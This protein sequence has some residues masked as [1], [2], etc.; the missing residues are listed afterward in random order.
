MTLL[1]NWSRAIDDIEE[2][3]SPTPDWEFELLKLG[4]GPLGYKVTQ[5]QLP[6]L[7]VLLETSAQTIRSLQ[8]KRHAAF[9]AATLVSVREP[10][11]WRGSEVTEGQV[12]VFGSLEH[13]LVL[14]EGGVWL[15]LQF[16]MEIAAATGLFCLPAGIWNSDL[17]AHR[18][19]IDQCLRLSHASDLSIL[20]ASNADHQRQD[21]AFML[22]SALMECLEAPAA[23][24][25]HPRYRLVKEADELLHA[26]A[27][28]HRA[29]VE[30]MA[31]AAGVPIRSFHRAFNEILGMGPASYVRLARLHSFH[32]FLKANAH[33]SVTEAALDAGFEHFGRAARYYRQHFGRLPSEF[34]RMIDA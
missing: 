13:D 21:I 5:V 11:R 30:D 8:L 15:T 17:K 25:A 1:V 12:L 28:D 32:R 27:I 16:S 22:A 10:A 7:E 23:I 3:F 18:V 14:P 31:Q 24:S 29:T 6:G 26:S 4:T 9:N 19:L 20:P 34:R 33:A 2:V